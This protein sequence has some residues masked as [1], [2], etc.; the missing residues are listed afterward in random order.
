MTRR[1]LQERP[2]SDLD[3]WTEEALLD[4]HPLWRELRDLGAGVWLARYDMW[5]FPRYR[6]VREALDDWE[7]FSSAQGAC[8]NETLNELMRGTTL[9]SDPPEHD[10][11]RGVL[12]KPLVGAQLHALEPEIQAEAEQL[13]NRLVER[14]SFDAATDL[15]QH[16]PM[17]IVSKQVGLPPEGRED[18]LTWARVAFDF[19]GP[20]NDRA[21]AAAATTQQAAGYMA[22]PALPDRLEPH[23]WAAKLF[24]AAERG[25]LT[26]VQARA[27]LNDYWGP[28]LDTTIF[29]TTSAIWLFA[30]HPDQWDILRA[31]PTLIPHAVNEVVR[32][33]SPISQ[34]SRVTTRDVEVDGGITVPAGSRVLMMYGSANRDERKW[35][36]AERFDIRR[37]PSDQL[38]FGFGEHNCVGQ[39]LARMEMRALFRALAKR[40]ERFEI[41]DHKPA[42]NNM[43]HG[44]ERLEV[45]ARGAGSH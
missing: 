23:G 24:E 26:D 7:V 21:K 10:H 34:F 27:L 8:L 44:I 4:P 15:A 40:V 5:A 22:D 39:A 11:L 2:E 3:L 14:G 12:R 45:R 41:L 38:G 16:L 37:K 19:A 36:D 6:E 31:D 43:L 9:A 28:S 35:E 25:E 29:A 30:Q 1:S 42:V 33:E 17:T 32:L 20:M 18:M 13:V